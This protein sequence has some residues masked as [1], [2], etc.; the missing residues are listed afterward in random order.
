ML[1]LSL[2]PICAKCGEK[3]AEADDSE[4]HVINQA[5]G[6][7][8]TV[9][10]LFHE[11]CNNTAGHT[12]DAELARQL[13]PLSLH[14][15]VKRQSGQTPRMEI[16]TTAGEKLILGPK[17]HL[18]MAKPD[19]KTKPRPDG[20]KD[21]FATVGSRTEARRL[22]E[23]L[24]R[25]NSDIDVEAVL[26][27][28]EV[29]HSYAKGMVHFQLE[30]GNQLAGRSIVKSMLSLA[31]DAGIAVDR[32]H[33]ALA[34]LR[35]ADGAP[36]FGY[37]WDRDVVAE[38]PPAVPLHCVAIEA[39]PET[40]LILGYAEYYGIYRAVG[41]LGR[42]F[43]GERTRHVYALD[44]RTGAALDLKVDLSFS[45]TDIE[46]IYEDNQVNPEVLRA[47]FGRVFGP[48]LQAQHEAERDRVLKEAVAYAWANCG[49]KEGEMLT[50]EHR[51]TISRLFAERV[52][53]LVLHAGG[54]SEQAARRRAEA[55]AD[56]LL[57]T[58]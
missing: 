5:I 46:S 12:W 17:G 22:L 35:E 50:H 14:F 15:D 1:S 20:K 40:G 3:I 37:Y 58:A 9:R 48:E 53:P 29:R 43:T 52:V 45:A 19:I 44:P 31:H 6:G 10:G 34:Y 21:L 42:G 25:K 49:A 7:R 55:Y 8:K 11:T 18:A 24:R 16:T 13:Q 2:P 26:A 38:R 28:A 23:G 57:R 27:S 32:C 4:E 39:S 33:D 51:H 30:F 36:C 56:F 54:A 47:A 41:C